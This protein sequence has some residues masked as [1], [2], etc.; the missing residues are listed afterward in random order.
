MLFR[1]ADDAT[2]NAVLAHVQQSGEAWMGGT[3]WDGRAAIR[4]SVSSWRTT[5]ADIDRTVAAFETALATV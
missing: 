2:T 5:E 4:V 3:T 1:F